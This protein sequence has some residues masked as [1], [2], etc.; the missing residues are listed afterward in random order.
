MAAP[1][2]SLPFLHA[3]KLVKAFTWLVHS[4]MKV[5]LALLL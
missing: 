2:M 5:R 3:K 1:G 4:D